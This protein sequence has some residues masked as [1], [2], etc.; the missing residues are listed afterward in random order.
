MSVSDIAETLYKH[1]GTTY[2]YNDV[3]EAAEEMLRSGSRYRNLE[4]AMNCGICFVLG[5][6]VVEST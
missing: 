1:D 5:T 2:P 3:M 4:R 6:V